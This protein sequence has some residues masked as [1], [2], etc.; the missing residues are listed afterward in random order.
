MQ[1][2]PQTK[3]CKVNNLNTQQRKYINK[4]MKKIHNMRE[5][6]ESRNT[7][8]KKCRKETQKKR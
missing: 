7:R 1:F 2:K 6:M 3:E 5:Q 8:R 4:R